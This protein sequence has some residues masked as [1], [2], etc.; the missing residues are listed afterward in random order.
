[1]DDLHIL[2]G[3]GLPN[4]VTIPA[5]ELTERF[6]HS[7]GPGG[8]G[9]NTSDSRVQLSLDISTTTALDEAQRALTLERLAV[10]LS[11]GVLTVTSSEHR[12]QSRN[13]DEAR[14]RL[15]E[16]LRKALAPT[17]P[18]RPTKPSQASRRR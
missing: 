15:A 7:S 8:Q 2:P 4:G 1:M 11:D 6:S 12:S 18:R 5:V 3:P 14:A 17:T 9:V 13:R 16:I 10:R